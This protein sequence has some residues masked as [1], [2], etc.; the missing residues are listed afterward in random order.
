[1][2]HLISRLAEFDSPTL[3]A[4]LSRSL[5]G[6][7]ATEETAALGG[8]TESPSNVRKLTAVAVREIAAAHDELARSLSNELIALV[9]PAFSKWPAMVPEFF[10]LVRALA[11]QTSQVAQLV[12]EIGSL[13]AREDFLARPLSDQHHVTSVEHLARFLDR[14]VSKCAPTPLDTSS[15]ATAAAAAAESDADAMQLER[16]AGSVRALDRQQQ[17]EWRHAGDTVR[18]VAQRA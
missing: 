11:V 2:Q 14:L 3:Q 12:N 5:L 8:A 6:I 13:L 4:W 10:P 16:E 9:A 18:G 7:E 15:T 1:M 17:V